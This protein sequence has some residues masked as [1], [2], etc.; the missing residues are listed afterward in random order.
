[1]VMKDTLKMS[2][3]TKE[4]ASAALAVVNRETVERVAEKVRQLLEEEGC[5]MIP[6]VTLTAGSIT[7]DII[8]RIK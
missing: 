6:T 7:S 5:E 1:M 4:E 2:E 8:I 3:I